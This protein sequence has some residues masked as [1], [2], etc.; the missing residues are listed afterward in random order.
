LQQRRREERNTGF[1][2]LAVK[3]VS[4][5]FV[6]YSE[7]KAAMLTEEGNN[8]ATSRGR[9]G[10]ISNHKEGVVAQT[11]CFNIDLIRT[12]HGR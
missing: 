12:S 4:L 11:G 6:S 1:K 10:E 8:G 9:T 2:V 7:A 3:V 5:R